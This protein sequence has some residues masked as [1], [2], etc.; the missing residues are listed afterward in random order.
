MRTRIITIDGPAG[1][2]KSTIS[3][4]LSKKLNCVYVDT[5][6]LYRGVAFE[7]Q[8]QNIDWED[9]GVLEDFLKNLDLNFVMEKDSL[10]LMSSGRDITNLIRTP[11]MSLLASSSS[12]KP[13]VRAALLDIQRNIAKTKDA[14]FEGR[15][16]G[17]I[18]FPDAAVK[19]F[20]F[21]DLG[22]R[23]KRRFDEM[24]GKSK[25]FN[26]VQKEMDIRDGNDSQRKSAPLKPAADAIE[27]DSS[28]MT[29]EQVVDKMLKIIEKA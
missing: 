28:F 8:R 3:K 23:A 6:A 15:D 16:M 17:T 10:I 1:A 21:A 12:A 25:D 7:I 22:V 24:P 20:L 19:F 18:V 9:D 2:G 27:I 26:K 14:V 29:I 4:L 13:Q 11:E 5:G